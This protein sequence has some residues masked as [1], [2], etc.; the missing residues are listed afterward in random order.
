MSKAPSQKKEVFISAGILLLALGIVAFFSFFGPSH[1]VYSGMN[2]QFI[3]PEPFAA[4]RVWADSGVRGRVLVLLDRKLNADA[5]IEGLTPA[6]YVYHAVRNDFVRK[7]YHIVPDNAWPEVE[8]ALTQRG[9]FIRTNSGFRFAIDGASV[10]ITTLSGLPA[11]NEPVM[12]NINGDY[13][14]T[15]N[16]IRAL[17]GVL[18]ERRVRYDILTASGPSSQGILE[19][20]KARS[21]EHTSEL[22]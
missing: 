6:N 19:E 13:L 17:C 4:Y 11:L 5:N 9:Y 20:L 2:R 14:K 3:I 21:E 22:Q 7:V 15:Q 12:I 1:R 10:S 16:D 18:R 8:R